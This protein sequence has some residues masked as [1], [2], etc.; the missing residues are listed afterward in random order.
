MS[1]CQTIS[2]SVYTPRVYIASCF[3]AGLVLYRDLCTWWDDICAED[4]RRDTGFIKSN[5]VDALRYHVEYIHYAD[6]NCQLYILRIRGYVSISTM[7]LFWGLHVHKIILI[8]GSSWDAYEK[9]KTWRQIVICWAL[10][11]LGLFVNFI[12][13]LRC[14]I[15]W[16]TSLYF[17]GSQQ[18][19]WSGIY[20]F[21]VFF[22]H[23]NQQWY[24]RTVDPA[25]QG[26]EMELLNSLY[27]T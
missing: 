7:V 24:T 3:E 18:R 26:K 11:F 21:R 8:L 17:P 20:H 23:F 14:N 16:T 19:K 1:P 27:S 10:L 22:T 13:D 2:W 15:S 9:Y 25:F 4:V 6:V 12:F 5:D